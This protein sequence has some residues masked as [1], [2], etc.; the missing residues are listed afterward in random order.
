MGI[1]RSGAKTPYPNPR[2]TCSRQQPFRSNLRHARD[3]DLCH[4]FVISINNAYQCNGTPSPKVAD[5]TN[6]PSQPDSSCV[7]TQGDHGDDGKLARA[8]TLTDSPTRKIQCTTQRSD[9]TC[10]NSPCMSGKSSRIRRHCQH[11]TTEQ[12]PCL[13]TPHIRR[14][15]HLAHNGH[16]KSNRRRWYSQHSRQHGRQ[17]V[18]RPSASAHAHSSLKENALA[19]PLLAP[20]T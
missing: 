20:L 19:L 11:Q 2:L 18:A 3:T 13:R 9:N 1:G 10:C 6:A 15:P 5:Q 7:C 16:K 14:C 17:G 12:R 8:Q 4:V